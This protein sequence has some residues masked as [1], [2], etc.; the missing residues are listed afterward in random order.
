MANE[1]TTKILE[2]QV[3][4]EKAIKGIAEYEQKIR[5][6]RQAQDDLRSALKDGTISQEQYDQTM[7]A[8]K[9]V[10]TQLKNEQAALTK[11]VR[12]SIEA[13]R[14]ASGS[15]VE[16]RANLSNLTAE[17]DRMSVAERESAKGKELQTKINS[18]TTAIK[19]EEE[20][21]QRF[22]RNVG[23]YENGVRDALTN[24]SSELTEAQRRYAK[25]AATMGEG[26]KEAQ[27][28]KSKMEGLQYVMDFTA[29]AT[30]NMNSKLY[31]FIPFGNQLSKLIPLVG[32]GWKG[33]AEGA[34]L[35]GQGISLVTKQALTFIA[36]PIGAAI[37][38]IA[39]VVLAFN[40]G[41]S[42]SE[43]NMDRFNKILAPAQR[44]LA[45]LQ[46]GLEKIAS[47]ALSVAEGVGFLATKMLEFLNVATFGAFD[48]VFASANEA[49]DLTEKEQ[50]LAKETRAFE[51]ENAKQQL[52]LAKLRKEADDKANKSSEER[53]AAA[54]KANDIEMHLAEERKRM[55][56]EEYEIAKARA[57]WAGN[58][59]K[60][61]EELARLE[62][63]MYSAETEYYNKSKELQNKQ[64]EIEKSIADE[65]K[66][67]SEE[68]KKQAEERA[69]TA[70]EASDKEL[71]AIRQAEDAMLVLVKDTAEKRRKTILNQYEREIEDLQKRLA[72]EKNLTEKAREAINQTIIA[73]Q[74]QREQLLAEVDRS[75]SEQEI[76]RQQERIQIMLETVKQG[77]E[78][79]YQ[80][81]L[82]RNR[83]AMEADLAATDQEIQNL[84]EREQMK[85]LIR[86]KYAEQEHQIN[87]ERREA[88]AE[89]ERQAVEN[90]FTERLMQVEENS[91]E[92][93]EIE[94]E[95]RKYELENL[96]Q[97]E[98]ESNAAFTARQLEAR[99]AYN[100]QKKKLADA[101]VQIE[102]AKDKAI[103]S[104]MGT[105]SDAITKLA[106][107]N[108]AAAQ[109]AKVVGMAEL[110]I[111]QAV[112]LSE[113]IKS[114]SKGDPY[115]TAA[116][117]AAAVTSVVVGMVSAFSSMSQA[118]FAHGGKVERENYSTG[119]S[120]RGAGTGTSDSIPAWLSNGE[121]VMTAAATKI[122]QPQ[123]EAMNAIGRGVIPPTLTQQV[124][125]GGMTGESI[126][127]SFAA[128]AA[129][130][131]P[132]VSVVDINDGQARVEAIDTLDTL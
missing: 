60:D 37:A 14:A 121:F 128:A 56:K 94:L 85:A 114:A 81:L 45:F 16:W 80:L 51:V 25:L 28:A 41:I 98:G 4:Y 27:E 79:E 53:I 47:V 105:V 92:A 32:K 11:Q 87:I 49:I 67:R 55:A 132:V 9:A 35:A 76:Q 21:T 3:N 19:A 88:I 24:M 1:T 115:T 71:A 31:S 48:G 113:A 15:L 42:S 108:K 93:A 13:E 33:F 40:K 44:L 109:M 130:I 39:T 58:S 126:T 82:D 97:M 111:N 119:G 96:H 18:L 43:E 7:A 12:K 123:L 107:D 122:F 62:A 99:K 103:A 90:E 50:T 8:S 124:S 6:A 72:E 34:K 120:V 78:Q 29:D 73:K 101:E 59:A 23:N 22:Y 118:K 54:K 38:A 64:N 36:T 70:K 63:A 57:E 65:R 30:E 66:K 89:E 116:R 52:E 104:I 95:R 127:D 100:D 61:N 68:A 106:G 10:V 110:W 75:V 17:F 86:A 129:E 69:K 20:A 5:E 2:I 125:I 112:A 46:T 74:Q 77:T 102:L 84:E 131:R 91:L 117:I 83:L 26:S